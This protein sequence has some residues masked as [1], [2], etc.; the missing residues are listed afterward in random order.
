MLSLVCLFGREEQKLTILYRSASDVQTP[1]RISHKP[2]VITDIM[3][4]FK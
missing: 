4:M 3:W 1:L 2:A